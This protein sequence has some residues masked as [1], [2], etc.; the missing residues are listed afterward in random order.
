[1]KVCELVVGVSGLHK[2]RVHATLW[3]SLYRCPADQ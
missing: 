3:F 1:M 2:M